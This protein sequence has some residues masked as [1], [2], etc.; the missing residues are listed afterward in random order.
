MLVFK[1]SM[2]IW[3]V[4][5][6]I[7]VTVLSS[8]NIQGE[9]KACKRRTRSSEADQRPATS[10]RCGTVA[11]LP[12]SN[13]AS[14]VSSTAVQKSVHSQ[15]GSRQICDKKQDTVDLVMTSECCICLD[16]FEGKQTLKP[17]RCGHVFHPLCIDKWIRTSDQCPLC[18]HKIN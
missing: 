2:K 4:L 3:N 7:A 12:T 8:L 18:K 14:T 5:G 15:P 16:S 9:Q 1:I 13:R 17:L 11:R 10:K 6:V